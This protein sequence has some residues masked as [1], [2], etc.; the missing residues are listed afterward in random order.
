[1]NEVLKIAP[2]LFMLLMGILLQDKRC[3]KSG[4]ELS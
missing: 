3:Q 1:M 2:K 4:T